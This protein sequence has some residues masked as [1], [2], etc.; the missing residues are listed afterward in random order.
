MTNKNPVPVI[1]IDGPAA[2]GKGTVAKQVAIALNF[3]Y[4]DSGKIYRAFT[5]FVLDQKISISDQQAL[6]N[7]AIKFAKNP[8][9][10]AQY[11]QSKQLYDDIISLTTSTISALSPIRLKLKQIQLMARKPP[12]LVTDGRDMGS[13][14]FPDAILKIYLVADVHIRAQRRHAQLV[15]TDVSQMYAD[16]LKAIEDRDNHDRHRKNSPLQ[17][18]ADMIQID[19]SNQTADKVTDKIIDIYLKKQNH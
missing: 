18:A 8:D 12:G 14:L 4:L 15:K 16:I 2:S 10:I 7:G 9:I 17:K 5:L 3:H 6:T 13:H 11:T 19:S 1:T